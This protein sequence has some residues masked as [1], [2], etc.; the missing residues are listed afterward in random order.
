MALLSAKYTR[1]CNFDRCLVTP[2]GAYDSLFCWTK[3]KSLTNRIAES[4]ILNLA[5]G[6]TRHADL[7]CSGSS[8][9]SP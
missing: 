8:S 2:F 3:L 6:S 4:Q 9:S 7:E 5:K 1:I